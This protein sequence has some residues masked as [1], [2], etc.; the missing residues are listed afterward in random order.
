LSFGD[1]GTGEVGC[2]VTFRPSAP[3]L[4]SGAAAGIPF[5]VGVWD[6]FCGGWVIAGGAFW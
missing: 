5:A 2:L 6:C 1:G 4:G 3:W